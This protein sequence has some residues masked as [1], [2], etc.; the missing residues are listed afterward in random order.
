M[1]I[2][3][4]KSGRQNSAYRHLDMKGVFGNEGALHFFAPTIATPGICGAAARETSDA[5]PLSPR[6]VTAGT[7]ESPL[8]PSEDRERAELE[9]SYDR[10]PRFLDSNL[11]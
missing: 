11:Q 6:H 2:P 5:K 4:E 9:R 8:R 1:I 3:P 10:F 7:L